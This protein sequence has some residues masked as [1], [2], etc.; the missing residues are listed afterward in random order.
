MLAGILFIVAGVLI[1]VY[2][3]L[4]SMIIAGMLIFIGIT[5]LII[6]YHYKKMAK[7]F[8]NPYVDFF[9]RF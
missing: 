9:F 1:A 2:P 7:H 3:P 8:E 4:L 6:G 5:L